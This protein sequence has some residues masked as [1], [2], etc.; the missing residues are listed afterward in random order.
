MTTY[1]LGDT[2]LL[3]DTNEIGSVAKI[4]NIAS[5]SYELEFEDGECGWYDQNEFELEEESMKTNEHID[6]ILLEDL[7]ALLVHFAGWENH[8]TYYT[9]SNGAVCF[10]TDSAS[11]E[12]IREALYTARQT[13]EDYA[14]DENGGIITENIVR[15][16]R[17]SL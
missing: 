3:T 4:I 9:D 16:V 12:E 5:D 2:V 6:A 10:S 11:Q 13:C 17:G 14:H 15:S 7:D 8:G 1:K